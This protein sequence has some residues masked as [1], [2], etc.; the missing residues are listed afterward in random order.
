[1]KSSKVKIKIAKSISKPIKVTTGLGQGN[2]LS[3]VFM[4]MLMEKV[5]RDMKLS[6]GLVQK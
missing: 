5:V 6:K 2:T 4:N 3:P 1:M